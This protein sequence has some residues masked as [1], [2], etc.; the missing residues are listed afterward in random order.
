LNRADISRAAAQGWQLFHAGN[1]VAADDVVRPWATQA[2]NDELVPL[3]G[4]IRL[5]QGRMAEA[6]PMFERARALHP[7][8][9]RF[10]FLHGTALAGLQQFEQAISAFQ[11][12]IRLDANFPDSYMALGMVLRKLGKP[13][14]AQNSYRKL[15]RLKPDHVDAYISLSAALAESGQ[16]AE[17]EAPLRRALQYARDPRTEAAI[18]NNLAIAL[19]SQN[20]HAEA[21]EAL[22][23]TQALTPDLPDLDQRRIDRLYQLGRY[24][25][26]LQ[27][28]RKLLDRDPADVKLHK[29]YNSLLFRLGRMG[30]FLAS[31]DRAPQTRELLFG[32]ARFLSLQ[33]RSD[34]VE[35]I[36]NAL[37]ARDPLDTA[38]LSGWA[39]N[40]MAQGRSQEA[41]AIF[42]S[43]LRRP[44]ASTGIFSAAATA[45]L[46]T[47]DP[48][49][50]EHFCQSGLRLAPFDQTC[51]AM[52]G[53]AW[54]LQADER[55]E[56]LN[57]YDSLIRVFDL[58]PPEGFSSMESFNA[59]LGAY[60]ERLHPQTDAYLDQ[61]LYGGTQTEGML[62]GAGHPLVEK[63]RAQ[64]ERAISS[65]IADLQPNG[66]HPFLARH[67]RNFRY[68]GAWSC[69]MRG[70]GFHTNHLHPE[71]WISSAYYVTVPK[72]TGDTQSRNGWIKFGE[73][74]LDLPLRD[75]VRRAVQPVPG[76]LVL[77]PSYMWHGTV[78]LQAGSPRTTI[79]FDVVPQ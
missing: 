38:A 49:K 63:I 74:S 48:Q 24:E 33:K 46:L 39:D 41:L 7:S 34:E 65:F 6:A 14:E 9:A 40:L 5:Q 50:A 66:D 76:R 1:L 27:L 75:A 57:G 77:F 21:L 42:E 47:G 12:A 15:L 44:G 78:P 2:G 11:A 35:A 13:E 72:E 3:I 45:A 29:A 79:A 43:V 17:A 67:S 55:D 61:S 60:L 53:T 19:S 71:G 30:E 69:L 64:I 22:E 32:K 10:A 52:L 37:L 25:E 68:S 18:H 26:C 62:F 59:E 70:Q 51:L 58:D 8:Q 31:Y 16:F 28:Y 56:A 73:P 54:R 23:R 36:Y 4:A 20:K